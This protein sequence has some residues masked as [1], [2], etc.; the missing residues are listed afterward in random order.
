MIKF[1][2]KFDILL[3]LSK[4]RK[5]SELYK[6]FYLFLLE[7]KFSE[8]QNVRLIISKLRQCIFYFNGDIYWI[9]FS[10]FN[11]MNSMIVNYEYSLLEYL[12]EF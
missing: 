1:I 10:M 7:W 12:L 9:F 8:N 3:Y 5:E 2:I 4:Y 6:F 11:S